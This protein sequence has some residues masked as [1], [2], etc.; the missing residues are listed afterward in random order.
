MLTGVDKY[1]FAHYAC[2]RTK[3]PAVF[4]EGLAPEL[5][6]YPRT[7]RLTITSYL[8]FNKVGKSLGKKSK[9]GPSQT[10]MKRFAGQI[11]M[12]EVQTQQVEQFLKTL[13]ADAEKSILEIREI[14]KTNLEG[15]A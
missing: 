13:I 3:K 8:N 1:K 6:Y 9:H 11:A 10:W 2:L 12:N 4:T 5:T 7:F 14:R 15:E